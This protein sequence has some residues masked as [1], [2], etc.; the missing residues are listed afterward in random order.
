MTITPY[1]LFQYKCLPMGL[2]DPVSIFQCLV[3]LTLAG[4]EGCISYLNDILV[5]GSMAMQHDERLGATLQCLSN[6]DFRLNVA[7]CQFAFTDV[8]FLGHLIL[9]TRI[10]PDPKSLDAIQNVPILQSITDVRS[11]LG[12]IS[13]LCEF[14]L[15]FLLSRSRVF[16]A[17]L[18]Q[19]LTRTSEQPKFESSNECTTAFNKLKSLLTNDLQP[20]IFDPDPVDQ[21]LLLKADRIVVPS[22]LRR[23]LMKKA[24]EGH[25]CIVRAKIKLRET[26]CCPGIAA[27]M[28]E[29]ICHCQSCQDSAKSNP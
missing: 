29:T 14:L 3:S 27:D 9:S 21:G 11:F 17:Q 6:K 23:Q 2:R 1:G 25:P 13:Y 28:E 5:F 22:K 16:F 15:L 10:K 8:P 26:Y 20:T 12:S 18:L 24:Q 4:C 7:K 19:H